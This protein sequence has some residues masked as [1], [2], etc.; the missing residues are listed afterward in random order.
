MAK[1][2]EDFDDFEELEMGANDPLLAFNQKQAK[3]QVAQVQRAPEK[4]DGLGFLRKAA[5]ERQRQE[6]DKAKM[7]QM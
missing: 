5:D 6:D 3:K 2:Q 1:P 7:M 4:D